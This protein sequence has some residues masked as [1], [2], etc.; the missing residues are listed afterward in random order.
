MPLELIVI[1]GGNSVVTRARARHTHKMC[2]NDQNDMFSH[3]LRSF[4]SIA[5]PLFAVQLHKSSHFVHTF[6]HI[7]PSPSRAAQSLFNGSLCAV[8]DSFFGGNH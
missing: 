4:A 3:S 7:C 1:G 5:W 8:R 6:K 2:Q